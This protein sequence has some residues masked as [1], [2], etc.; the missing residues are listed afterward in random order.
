MES[1]P[2]TEL[3]CLA[4]VGDDV[5]SPAETSCAGERAKVGGMGVE[6]YPLRGEGEAVMQ[7]GLHGRKPGGRTVCWV[8]LWKTLKE[9][10]EREKC[11]S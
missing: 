1:V 4:S 10:K 3:P 5:P 11:C 2:L 6:L 8:V 7:E 9:R